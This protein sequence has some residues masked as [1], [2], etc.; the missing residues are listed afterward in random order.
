MGSVADMKTN[1]LPCPT[2]RKSGHDH[3]EMEKERINLSQE[4]LATPDIGGIPVV[5]VK[6]Q[7]T[8]DGLH[9]EEL[10]WK[11]PYGRPTD[12]ILLKPANA[13][14][15]LPGNTGISRSWRK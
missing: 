7:Y 14:G 4:R 15:P 1:C 5:T 11:L 12:A 10:S 2:G 3:Q 9:I 8:Y 6:K 13:S